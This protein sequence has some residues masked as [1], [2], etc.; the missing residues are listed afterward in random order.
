MEKITQ[1]ENQWFVKFLKVSDEAPDANFVLNTQLLEEISE[2]DRIAKKQIAEN[3]YGWLVTKDGKESLVFNL[4]KYCKERKMHSSI[5][6]KKSEQ[7][8]DY[9]GY[10]VKKN[11]AMPKDLKSEVLELF[12]SRELYYFS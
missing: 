8:K 5:L 2:I 9:K 3:Y 11:T 12:K 1:R 10:T 4:S 6:V 7:G